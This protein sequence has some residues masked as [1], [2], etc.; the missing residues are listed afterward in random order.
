MSDSFYISATCGGIGTKEGLEYYRKAM[1]QIE[2]VCAKH[3]AAGHCISCTPHR[4][5]HATSCFVRLFSD[6]P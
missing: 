3:R 2:E 5:A 1:D 4:R 6:N